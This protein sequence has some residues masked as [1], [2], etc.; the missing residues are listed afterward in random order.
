MPWLWSHEWSFIQSYSMDNVSVVLIK[1]K[2]SKDIDI[3]NQEVKDKVDGISYNLPKDSQKPKITKMDVNSFPFMD[4]VLA[5]DMDGKAL[6]ELADKKLK[7][8]FAQMKTLL[9]SP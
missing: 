9:K 8:R 5:G 7:D 3:A 4:I 1:F 2:L 6:Y